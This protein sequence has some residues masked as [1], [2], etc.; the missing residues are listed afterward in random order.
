MIHARKVVIDTDPGID[1]AL[2]IF[3][4]LAS[5]EIEVLGLTSVFGNAA[6]EVT[7]RNA[8]MLLEIAGRPDIP[9]AAGADRPLAGRYAGAVPHIH[10]ADGQGDAGA[11]V[12]P[13]RTPLA[14]PAAEFLCR[15]I[16]EHAGEVT[17]LA[18]G[19]LTNLA[20]ALTLRPSIAKEAARVV[21]MGGSALVPGN[22]NAA[23]EANIF[24]D[25]E[26][27]DMVF[28]AEW[29]V[30]MV[31]LDV[32]HR[33]LLTDEAIA[34]I[35]ASPKATSRHIA[36]A[37]PLYR[38]FYEDAHRLNGVYLHDPSAVAYILDAT[39][40]ETRP[41]PIRIETEGAARGRS[42]PWIAH[43]GDGA[44]PPGKWRGRKPVDV[45]IGVDSARLIELIL[46][47]LV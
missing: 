36:A 23:A 28:A 39:L 42:E 35:A 5:P 44:E 27:A 16:A 20:Q 37:L 7:T 17:L 12:E 4:A 47:R 19:P 29:P 14:V 9:V 41:W 11:I 22:V 3:L 40:F 13:A 25:A 43:N 46:G 1:D 18:I 33:A 34:R 38:T 26:A 6:V 24:N 31:G 2:A 30:A 8:L 21:I 10:G 15:T 32:T 45:C